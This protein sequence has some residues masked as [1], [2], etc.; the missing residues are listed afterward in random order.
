MPYVDVADLDY[1]QSDLSPLVIL[2]WIAKAEV[3]LAQA[4]ASRGGD[5]DALAMSPSKLAIIQ[6]VLENAVA[7]VLRNPEGLR[8][9]SEGD[10]SYT[11]NALDASGNVWFPDADLDAVYAAPSAYGSIRLAV[12]SRYYQPW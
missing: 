5:L 12:P 2:K 10:Y 3:R 7:R 4:I 9:E 8:S 11:V 1:V 6:D